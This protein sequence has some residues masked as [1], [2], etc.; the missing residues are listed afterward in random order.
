MKLSSSK[1]WAFGAITLTVL[2][3][4]SPQT[5]TP[6]PQPA[7]E[8]PVAMAPQPIPAPAASET[9]AE[10]P[11]YAGVWALADGDCGDAARTLNLSSQSVGMAPGGKACVIKS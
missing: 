9:P 2:I 5:E 4:C 11:G 8:T 1:R 6:P 3:A 10:E 7:P